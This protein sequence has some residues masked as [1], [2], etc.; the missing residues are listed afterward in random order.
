MCVFYL[1]ILCSR[2]Q[3]PITFGYELLIEGLPFQRAKENWIM[4]SKQLL[5]G[6]EDQLG[7]APSKTRRETQQQRHAREDQLLEEQDVAGTQH[8]KK[9]GSRKEE[10]F[11]LQH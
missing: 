9:K 3:K 1:S 11:D 10:L 7:F 5:A 4:E 6:Y 2:E 8:I